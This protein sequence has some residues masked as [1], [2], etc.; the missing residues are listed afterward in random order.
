MRVA[1]LFAGMTSI[2]SPAGPLT[3]PS[4]AVDSATPGDHPLHKPAQ[5]RE[6]RTMQAEGRAIKLTRK[7]KP[8]E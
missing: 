8:T 3:A 5:T 1:V 7:P 4:R 2:P 6:P